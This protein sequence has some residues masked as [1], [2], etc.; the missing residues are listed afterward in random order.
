M[1]PFRLGILT[2]EVSQS[3]EEAI[4]FALRHG[5]KTLELRS[6]EGQ[7]IQTWSDEQVESIR[8][9]IT[10]N[11]LSVCALS[12]P[13]FKC[14]LSQPEEVRE[15]LSILQRSIEIAKKLGAPIIRG[16]SFWAEETFE[17]AL[18]SIVEQI[19][20]IAP[21][22]EK[23][24]RIFALEFDPG[25]YASNAGKV[26]I[27]LDA[28]QSPNVMALYDP[29]ND[30]WD[31]DGEIPYPDGYEYLKGKICHIHL[32]DAVRT[33]DG[34]KGVAIGKGEV[35]Y[36]GLL[37]RLMMDQYEGYLVV[38]THYRLQA[39]LS[40]AQ[41]KR[42]AGYAFSEGGWAASEECVESLKRLIH[43]TASNA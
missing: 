37:R 23:E 16:F 12:T 31:P 5:M 32:K 40:E 43:E 10:Q 17:K 27:I 19:R 24:N 15:H 21:M 42:P 13:I 11:H 18:P 35:D 2:D 22:L 6:I 28:V 41:L 7:T 36:R 1:S 8:A 39:E 9:L 33:P 20:G 25:V 29:G 26:R 34:V 38:E 14:R 30:V 3:L 4:G